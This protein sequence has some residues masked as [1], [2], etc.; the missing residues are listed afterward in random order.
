MPLGH[1][2][3]SANRRIALA[4]IALSTSAFVLTGRGS[5]NDNLAQRASKLAFRTSGS[6]FGPPPGGGH[7]SVV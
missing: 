7:G 2:P 1:I 3:T 5:D 4:A 6:V